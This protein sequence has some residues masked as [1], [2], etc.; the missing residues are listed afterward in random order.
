MSWLGLADDAMRAITL[1]FVGC[2]HLMTVINS[3]SQ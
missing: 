2:Y 1:S 3:N